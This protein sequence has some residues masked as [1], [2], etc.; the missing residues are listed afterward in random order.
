MKKIFKQNKSILIIF[1]VGLVLVAGSLLTVKNCTNEA[2]A[3]TATS[4]VLVTATVQAWLSFSLSATS[5]TLAPDLVN[6]AGGTSI[7]SSSV[8]NLTLG[9]NATG[10]YSVSLISANGALKSGGYSI[11]SA[12]N[13]ASSTISA[14]TNNY[15]VEGSSTVA[16]VGGIYNYWNSSIIGPAASTSAVFT[17]HNIQAASEVTAMKI[18]AAAAA[19]QF[20][21]TYTDTITL[22]AVTVP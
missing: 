10:G 4:S 22:T 16:T 3:A 19:T 9:T 14:G 13:T 2:N 17:S 20:A 6:T 12:A 11:Q 5:T 21:G 15:G 18:F 8:I 1:A 7:G